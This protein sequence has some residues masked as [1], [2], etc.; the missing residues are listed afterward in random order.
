MMKRSAVIPLALCIV[1]LSV[2]MSVARAQQ[3]PSP[4]TDPLHRPFD[5]V[6]DLYVRDGLVYYRALRSD[7]GRLD[8]YIAALGSTTKSTY[9]GWPREQ[10]MAF[11]VNAY[12]AFVLQT[13]IQ[14]YP[15]RGNS[16]RNVPG[17]FDQRPHQAAGRTV[18]LDQIEK[19]ILPE[20]RDPRLY[21]A[22]G[23][24]A[25]GSGRLRSEVYTGTRMEEQLKDQTED[26]LG[27]QD[28]VKIDRLA[29]EIQISPILGWH[30]DEFI[31]AYS[32]KEES[33]RFAKRSPIE[34]AALALVGP[35]LLPAEREFVEKGE[36]KVVYQKFD[37]TLNE[38]K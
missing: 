20:F 14:N 34:R 21:F 7:R 29:N 16:I 18:T 11:W 12:N 15:L 10:K 5:Q 28:H 8:R 6:L 23:R 26:F 17:A 35:V 13:V 24:G 1:Q 25:M 27:R 4:S 9:D 33:A 3:T 30:E 37:W 22:L 36:F 38:L 32:G 2:C 31:A 19:K